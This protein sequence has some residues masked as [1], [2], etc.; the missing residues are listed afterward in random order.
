MKQL[1]RDKNRQMGMR[2]GVSR[3]T[4]EIAVAVDLIIVGCR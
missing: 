4:S 1:I 2:F 3:E